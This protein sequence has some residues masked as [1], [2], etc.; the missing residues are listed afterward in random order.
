ME[1]A[2]VEFLKWG[3]NYTLEERKTQKVEIDEEMI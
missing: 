2:N 3:V 1:K